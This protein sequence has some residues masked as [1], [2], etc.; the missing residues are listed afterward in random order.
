MSEAGKMYRTAGYSQRGVS[1][2]EFW[3]VC[4]LL[5]I[6]FGTYLRATR[7]YQEQMEQVSVSLTISHIQVGMAQEWADRISKGTNRQGVA[8]LVGTNPVRWL[9]S[10]P[11]GFLGELKSPKLERLEPGSWLFDFSKKELVYIVKLGDHLEMGIMPTTKVLRWS[12]RLAQNS[13]DSRSAPEFGD[14]VLVPVYPYQWF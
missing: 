3:L 10:P 12:V 8:E 13:K 7:Y 6:L 11:P 4:I 5:A 14:L 9:E 2:L 1:Q